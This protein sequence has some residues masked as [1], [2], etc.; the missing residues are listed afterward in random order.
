[1]AMSLSFLTLHSFWPLHVCCVV[2]RNAWSLVGYV[3]ESP[4]AYLR[5]DLLTTGLF[6]VVFSSL[7]L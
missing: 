6:F 7:T 3:E 4:C 2:L 1:M 5:L